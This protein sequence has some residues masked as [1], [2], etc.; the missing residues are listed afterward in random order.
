[1]IDRAYYNK[2]GYLIKRYCMSKNRI[3]IIKNE[4][5]EHLKKTLLD[6]PNGRKDFL[7]EDDNLTARSIKDIHKLPFFFNIFSNGKLGKIAQRILGGE[8]EC[9]NAKTVYKPAYSGG[10]F[11][12]HQDSIYWDDDYKNKETMT[13]MLFLEDVYHY[14]A[15]PMIIPRSHHHGTIDVPHRDN[16]TAEQRD[17]YPET[18]TKNMQYSIPNS[19]IRKQ[20]DLHGIKVICGSAGT[21][22]CINACTIHSSNLNLS[23]ISRMN[24]VVRYAK[25]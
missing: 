19:I 6:A 23:P 5:N 17:E 15:P 1:M 4:A 20:H 3:S 9:F 12:W 22:L 7:I 21:L 24:L 13:M 2:N 25:I 18:R 14:N 16:I 8:V 11:D 10:Q